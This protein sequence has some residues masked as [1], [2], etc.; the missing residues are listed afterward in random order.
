MKGNVCSPTNL[1]QNKQTGLY[2][3]DGGM[4]S[5]VT[6]YIMGI[7]DEQNQTWIS[8]KSCIRTSRSGGKGMWYVS[9]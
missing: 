5:G 1:N 6:A 8:D 7:Q 3:G 4:D 2:L 9:Q